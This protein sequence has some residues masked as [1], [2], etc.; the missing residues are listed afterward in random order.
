MLHHI[1][2]IFRR[3]H[4]VHALD[5]LCR[6]LYHVWLTH[7]HLIGVRQR[8]L[9][10]ERIQQIF[11]LTQALREA[12]ARLLTAHIGNRL[13]PLQRTDLCSQLFL[14]VLLDIILHIDT[15][16]YLRLEERCRPIHIERE[17]EKDAEDEKRYRNRT[18]R[19]ERHPI[20]A[21]QGAKNLLH[22]VFGGSNLHIHN[23]RA[24][25]HA[26]CARPQW[27]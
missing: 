24:A 19:R 5:L 9:V 21:A 14:R 10:P 17:N 23:L 25:H 27:Q 26:Q 7:S 11:L 1:L 3:L 20:V 6:R 16:L 2:T 4:A 12:C 8:I 15:D 22:I 18:D 13:D